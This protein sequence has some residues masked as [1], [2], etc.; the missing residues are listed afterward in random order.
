MT[1]ESGNKEA[2]P[3]EK[4]LIDDSSDFLFH[5][6]YLTYSAAFDRTASAEGKRQLNQS[7]IA[8]QQKQVDYAT[9]YRSISQYRGDDGSQYHHGRPFIE[10]QRKKDW[11]RKT[12]KTERMK[13]HRR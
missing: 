9:F 2:A 5:A 10:T 11:R 4:L 7:V 12:Q 8:L 1:E 13:R 3:L 6:A